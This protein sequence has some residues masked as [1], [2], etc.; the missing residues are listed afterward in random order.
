MKFALR[1]ALKDPGM[2]KDLV[3]PILIILL[4]G[5][6]IFK[7]IIPKISSIGFPAWIFI[8]LWILVTLGFLSNLVPIG[9]YYT[10]DKGFIKIR[11]GLG[12]GKIRLDDINTLQ[13]I[14][15]DKLTALLQTLRQRQIS[16]NPADALSASGAFI[17][18]IRHSTIPVRFIDMQVGGGGKSYS[19]LYTKNL[20][21]WTTGEFVL[22]TTKSNKY[23]LLSPVDVDGFV[24][25]LN[26]FINKSI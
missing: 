12:W 6:V 24:R 2:N 17:D 1:S 22:I 25:Y 20:A 4:F 16:T 23:Y 21:A 19:R 10:V 8:G 9:A 15:G 7:F 18:L 26:S 11:K 3:F 13:K 14:S 5:I